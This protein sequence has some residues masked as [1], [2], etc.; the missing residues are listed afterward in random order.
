MKY[1]YIYHVWLTY[2][3]IQLQAVSRRS[4]RQ[5]LKTYEN[6]NL[7]IILD[8]FFFR[9]HKPWKTL[10]FRWEHPWFPPWFPVKVFPWTKPWDP[11]RLPS[12]QMIKTCNKQIIVII[13]MHLYIYIYIHIFRIC[14]ISYAMYVH[15]CVKLEVWI[16][17][18]ISICLS[19]YLSTYIYLPITYIA[20]AP[21]IIRSFSVL[22]SLEPS[23]WHQLWAI[24]AAKPMKNGRF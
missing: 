13:K 17:Q 9:E 22:F 24:N 20:P 8:G 23:H 16:P 12:K 15:I 3:S 10:N 2:T 6:L 19:V 21:S 7:H 14:H 5:P 1:I 11:M 4:C 18:S